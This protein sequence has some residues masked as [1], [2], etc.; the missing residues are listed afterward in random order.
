MLNKQKDFN[1][2]VADFKQAIKLNPKNAQAYYFLGKL[3]DQKIMWGPKTKE[4]YQKE[5]EFSM[6]DLSIWEAHPEESTQIIAAFSK[7]IQLNPKLVE[8]WKQ[9]AEIYL[10]LGK[11]EL[12]I[13]DYDKIIQLEPDY[14]GTYHDRAIAYKGLKDYSNAVRDLTKAIEMKHPEVLDW[15]RSAYEIR[16][17]V[18]AMMEQNES[19]IDDYTKAI[20]IWEEKF[21]KFNKENNFGSNVAYDNYSKRAA[22]L[23]KMA[24]YQDAVDSFTQAIK[25]MANFVPPSAYEDRGDVYMKMGKADFAVQDFTNALELQLEQKNSEISSHLKEIGLDPKIILGNNEERKI[26]LAE[27]YKKYPKLD[28]RKLQANVTAI[29]KGDVLSYEFYLKRAD[30]YST[31]EDYKSAVNDYHSAIEAVEEFPLYEGEGYFKLGIFYSVVTGINKEAVKAFTQAIKF[32]LMAGDNPW[33]CYLLRGNANFDI[34]NT[35]DALSDFTSAIAINPKLVTTRRG[36]A[37]FNLKQYEQAIKDFDKAVE[38]EPTDSTAYYY[39]GM[40]LINIDKYEQGLYDMKIAARL[41]EKEA[42]VKLKGAN[43]DW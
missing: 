23:K 7:A 36:V 22:L 34:G 33:S 17:H 38:L 25:S 40:A 20:E 12:A 3:Y 1:T 19:A 27:A 6:K 15:P 18:Y 13:K 35:T 21:G 9:R 4:D 39:R 26:S 24:R 5:A 8:A 43:I 14:A 37:F 11:Y 41:G 30:A 16:A 2:A 31:L 28:M 32:K 10:N 29:K 42:Q